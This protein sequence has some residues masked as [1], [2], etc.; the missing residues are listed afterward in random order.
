[1]PLS[2]FFEA[3]KLLPNELNLI[4]TL[5]GGESVIAK[6]LLLLSELKYEATQ[7]GIKKLLNLVQPILFGLIAIFILIAYLM[8]LMPVY[9]MMKGMN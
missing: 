9:G 7:A 2:S 8:I 5:G 3:E 4:F 6:D 1:M